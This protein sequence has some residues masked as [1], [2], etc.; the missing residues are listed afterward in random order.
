MI[1]SVIIPI[2]K[3]NNKNNIENYRP[4]SIIAQFSKII[5]KIIKKRIDNFI[6]KHN[7]ISS[8]QYGFKKKS[9]TLHAIYSLTNNITNSID[10]H[11]KIDIYIVAVFV[12]IKKAFDTIDHNILLIK[13]YKYGI[14]A[15]P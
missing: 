1:K 5:K 3:N 7:I 14:R 11:D 13:L 9:K 6:E 15:Y 10:N 2:H 12:D 4:I 8:N